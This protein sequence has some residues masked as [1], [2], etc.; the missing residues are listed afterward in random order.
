MALSRESLALAVTTV[1]YASAYIGCSA[2]LITSN[3]YILQAGR[4]PHVAAMLV[5]HMIVTTSVMAITHAVCPS[6]FP[7][8]RYARENMGTVMKYMLPLSVCFATT[9]FLSNK[10]YQYCSVAFL[11]FCKEGNVPMIYLLA[12]FLGLQTLSYRKLA[13]ICTMVAGISMTVHG[14][15]HFVW[16]GFLL[17]VC[18]QVAE[19]C[20]NQLSEIIMTDAGIKLDVL[21]FV[22]FQ[23]PLALMMVSCYLYAT[24]TP[25]VV[26]DFMAMWPYLLANAL[27]AASVNVSIAVVLKKLSAVAFVIIGLVKDIFIV[28][29]S[30][31]LLGSPISREQLVGFA[32]VIAAIAVWSFDKLA[33]QSQKAKESVPLVSNK[34]SK[35]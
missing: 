6:L 34:P 35:V 14:E 33:E 28:S 29:C 21:T 12:C 16:F 30:S 5:G 10:A 4:F 17:Q 11:Q 32:I 25:S 23:A 15:M 26:T 8:M 9:M 20:K 1:G 2:A 13:L 22:S 18:S 24:W 3:S 27:L 7:K 19:I 31:L